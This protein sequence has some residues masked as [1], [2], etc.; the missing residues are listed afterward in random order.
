MTLFERIIAREIPAYIMYEDEAFIA[1]LDIAQATKGHT[2][3]VPKTVSESFL[4]TDPEIL[5]N[6]IALAQKLAIEIVDAYGAKGVNILMNSGTIAGQTV[7]HVH[8]H[9]IPRYDESELVIKTQ[10]HDYDIREIHDI[11]LSSDKA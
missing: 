10:P 3:V 9:I 6:L 11:F 7:P 8:L 1:F 4:T 5:E 2:L